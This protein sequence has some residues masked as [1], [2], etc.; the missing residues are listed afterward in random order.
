MPTILISDPLPESVE[1]ALVNLGCNVIIRS[2]SENI[3]EIG[4]KNRRINALIVRSATKVTKEVIDTFHPHLKLIVR[5]GVGLDN[6]DVD[7]ARLKGVKVVNTPEASTRSVAE[8]TIAHMLAL[9][10]CLH[11][12]NREMPEKGNTGFSTLKKQYAK[13][14]HELFGK[15]LLIIGLGRIGKKVAGLAAGLGMKIIAHDPF[16]KEA[17]V[18]FEFFQAPDLPP[19]PVCFTVKSIPLEQALPLADFITIHTPFTG[20]PI[21]EE[22]HF[23]LMKPGV[24]IINCARGGVIP[25]PLLLKYAQEGKVAGFA[26]DVFESEPE[27]DINVLTHEKASLSPH[28]GASTPEAQER[29]GKEVVKI[30]SEFFNLRN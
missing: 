10:R 30:V 16:V 28:I 12:S 20:R 4:Q 13:E 8:L 2:D 23:K 18:C 21:L 17:E 27:P 9:A 25:E 3:L 26:L 15:T 5:A 7:Y 1:K 29:I 14:S 24:Y 19:A 22:Q 11:K 6:I